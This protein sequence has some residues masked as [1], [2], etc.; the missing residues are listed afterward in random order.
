LEIAEGRQ[1]PIIPLTIEPVCS[2]G[3][4]RYQLSGLQQVDL[5]ADFEAGVTRLLREVRRIARQAGVDPDAD[6]P[7]VM[8]PLDAVLADPGS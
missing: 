1:T 5:T 7:D 3:G 4:L 2:L 6:D 8:A